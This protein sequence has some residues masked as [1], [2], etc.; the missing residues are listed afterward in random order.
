MAGVNITSMNYWY[1]KV[2]ELGIP[3]PKTKIL[4]E[5]DPFKWY[6]YLDE[7]MPSDEINTIIQAANEIGYPL[8][9][10][11]DLNSGKHDFK[12]TCYVPDSMTIFKNL[13][14]LL[15]DN[16]IKDQPITSI[17]LREYIEPAWEFKAFNGLPI[18]PE[19]RYFVSCGEVVCHHAYWCEDSIEFWNN[20]RQPNN[21]KD[22]LAEMN[23][24]T[25]LEIELLTGYAEKVAHALLEHELS[26]DFMKARRNGGEWILIDIASAIQSWHPDCDKA[27]KKRPKGN[28]DE[29]DFS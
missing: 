22:V 24:E 27:T 2:Q 5:K 29:L 4:L 1:P 21:W 18:A 16:A 19:R 20:Q 14:G 13:Y 6:V 25:E 11:S 8:F 15:E 28:L 10:R 3:L 26:V 12:N 23:E 9:M 17:V 7:N